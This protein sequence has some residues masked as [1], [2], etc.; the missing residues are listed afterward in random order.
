MLA[1]PV[2][3]LSAAGCS[4]Q[5]DEAYPTYAVAQRAGATER[6]WVPAFVPSSARDIVGSHDLDTNRQ[7]LRFAIPPSEAGRMV[8]GLR[9]VSA[10]DRRPA[11]DLS[12]K[13]GLGAASEAYVVCAEPL[14]GVLVLDRRSGRAVYDTTVEWA[15]DDCPG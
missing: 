1:I 10:R 4:E 6:G 12:G 13:H 9:Q 2:L 3:L 11:A 8:A 14:S 7:T 5:V 15:E